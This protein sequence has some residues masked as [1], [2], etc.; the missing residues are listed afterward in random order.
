MDYDECT[1][2]NWCYYYRALVIGIVGRGFVLG[3]VV[4]S[5]AVVVV[6]LT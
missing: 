2:G 5:T 1:I 6:I 4:G 3:I